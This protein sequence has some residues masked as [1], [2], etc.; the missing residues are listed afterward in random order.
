MSELEQ[1]VRDYLT[2]LDEIR[3]INARVKSVGVE[4]LAHFVEKRD[5]ARDQMNGAETRMRE[6]LPVQ[7]PALRK[8]T[9]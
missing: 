2:A 8:I 5:T 1:A 6:A 7:L 9:T 3:R 4:G